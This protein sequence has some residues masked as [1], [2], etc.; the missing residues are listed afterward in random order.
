MLNLNGAFIIVSI[1]KPPYVDILSAG[2]LALYQD[3]C[4]IVGTDKAMAAIWGTNAIGAISCRER[5][6]DDILANYTG[7]WET[8]LKILAARTILKQYGHDCGDNGN[9]S[10]G[11]KPV[12]APKPAPRKPGPKGAAAPIPAGAAGA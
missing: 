2:H 7:P 3:R 11:G 10:D 6:L 12:D 8:D 5:V 1:N 9:G 4:R